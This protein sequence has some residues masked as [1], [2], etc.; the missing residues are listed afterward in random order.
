MIRLLFIHIIMHNAV[1]FHFPFLN[2]HSHKRNYFSIFS[3]SFNIKFFFSFLFFSFLPVGVLF[4]GFFSSQFG[5]IQSFVLSISF[6]PK[7]ISNKCY[8]EYRTDVVRLC[9]VYILWNS[10]F[11]QKKPHCSRFEMWCRE[12]NEK[13]NKILQR[14]TTAII[15]TK[16]RQIQICNRNKITQHDEPNKGK[17]NYKRMIKCRMN[18]MSWCT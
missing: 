2:C 13:N 8:S 14:H 18:M 16:D 6:G 11:R 3:C 4:V 9:F 12:Y 15:T 10:I 1:S 5:F 17:I 7:P